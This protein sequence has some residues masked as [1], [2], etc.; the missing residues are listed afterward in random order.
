MNYAVGSLVKVRGRE[1]VVLPESTPDLLV[2]RPLGGTDEEVTGVY[3][4]LEPVEPAQ[5]ALPDPRHW[6]DH[7]SCSLLRDAVRFGFRASTGPFRSFAHLAFEPRPYQLVPL[8][9]ALR[10][11]PVRLL[12]AD[13][14]GIGKTIEAGL[15]ARE[16]LDR[17]E[18][19]RLAVLCPPHLA[20][21][22]QAEL[23]EKFHIEAE[24]VLSSTVAQ[25]ERK[26]PERDLSLFEHYPFVIVSLDFIKADRRRDEFLRTCPELVIVDEAHTCAFPGHEHSARHQRYQLVAGLAADPRRH[27]ILATATPHSGKE[28]SFRSLLGFLKD[29]F[30]DLPQNLSGRENERHRL[31]LAEHF[32]Q[33]RRADIRSYL[34][35]ET[36]F[37]ERDEELKAYKLS[38]R[39]RRLMQQALSYAGEV[40]RDTSGGQTRRRVRWWSALALLRSLA[41]SPAAAAA[42]LRSR[43]QV[44]GAESVEEADQIGRHTVLDLLDSDATESLDVVPGSDFE[45]EDAHEADASEE[46][47]VRR[48][49]LAMA[50]EAEA[51]TFAQDTKLQVAHQL[52]ADLLQQG[53]RPIVFCRFIPTADYVAKELRQH[54]PK[55]VEVAAITGLLP[56]AERELRVMQLAQHERRVLVCTD[57]LS[58]GINLQEYF[59]AVLHYDLSWNPTR[60]EQRE[61]RVDRFGQASPRVKVVTLFGEDNQ[62]DGVVLRVLIQKHREIR[63]KLGIS[64]PVPLDTEQVIE[65]IFEGLLLHES[66]TSAQAGQLLLP[67][68]EDL[69]KGEQKNL[70]REW[71]AASDRERRSRTLFAQHGIRVDEVERELQEVRAAIGLSED[72]ERFTT[73]VLQAYGAFLKRPAGEPD[74]LEVDLRETPTALRDAIDLLR[75]AGPNGQQL[76]ISFRRMGL[77]RTLYLSR[78]HPLIEGLAA[79]VL[80][81]AL[82]P[83]DDA[84][85]PRLARRCGVFR[86]SRVQ[87][88]TTL[89]LVRLRFQ[90]RMATRGKEE[91]LLAEECQLYA[92][93][94]APA[95]AAWIEDA[96]EVEALAQEPAEANLAPEQITDFLQRVIDGYTQYLLPYLEERARERAEALRESH[97]R[98]RQVASLSLRHLAV[99]PLLPPDVLGIYVYLPLPAR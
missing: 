13:D 78:T 71:E 38:D 93:R 92:F 50:R 75:Y 57:C 52:I 25:L 35:S 11:D 10:L 88:R 85:N 17:R 43:A 46:R 18:V 81:T 62:I 95:Q 56:P 80:D 94:G 60:H 64:V 1:W 33:R 45:E 28:E 63:S 76:R 98:V 90:L 72:V 69:L 73:Q 74:V 36:P 32:V 41:S 26:L 20:E 55:G 21:Q 37:P 27:L 91:A 34:H 23:R 12:I 14:V 6:G 58:E 89:L 29:E 42:T 40:V 9:M 68:F 83:V 87:T 31:R 61:G 51:I 4:P 8:L 66:L 97:R 53:Y 49:L 82:D 84:Q 22:W 59:N 67:G 99:E 48:R 44:A 96:A 47:K 5:F 77:P 2:L 30:K 19:R 70:Y 65:A 79:Y 3:L 24:L 16:L 7:R 86:T 15:I 39:Y 54:L